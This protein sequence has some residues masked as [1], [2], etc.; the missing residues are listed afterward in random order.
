MKRKYKRSYWL[1]GLYFGIFIADDY[2]LF[3]ILDSEEI[4]S[5]LYSHW[6]YLRDLNGG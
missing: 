5:A 4:N 2:G 3:E 6:L 1:W